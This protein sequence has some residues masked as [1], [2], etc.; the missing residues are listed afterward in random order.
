M[1]KLFIS[2]MM[3]AFLFLFVASSWAADGD[4][5]LTPITLDEITDVTASVG[6]LNAVDD[7][8]V[9]EILVGGGAAT[10]PVWGTDIP[11][12]VT[13]GTAYIYR[14]D[15]T[16]VP[17]ADVADDITITNISQVQDISASASEINTP[18]DGASVTLTEF[19]ELETLGDTT[20]SANQW[21][22]LG[23]LAE[24]LTGAEI[25]ILDG[26]TGVTAAELSYIGDVTGL[27][28]AQIDSLSPGAFGAGSAKTVASG[29]ITAGT[30][31]YLIVTGEGDAVDTVTEIV[32]SLEGDIIV[33]KGKTG[34]AYNIT[35]EDGA[36]LELQANFTMN[37]QADTLTL[38]CT[39]LGVNDVFTEMHRA[40]NG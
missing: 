34:L 22:A 10:T 21:A 31:N 8:L 30:S 40:S 27:I 3:G 28:Q 14:A 4:P 17:D 19:M 29:I 12:A 38:V 13:I 24:T 2:L 5:V 36:Y 23:D 15:G 32:A 1:K 26:V 20:I 39:T 18:L 11:T 6:T 9:T 16:D 33:L 37:N 7:G 35:F 25:N